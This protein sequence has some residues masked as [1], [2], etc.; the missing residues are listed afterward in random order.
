MAKSTK[1]GVLTT[2]KSYNFVDKDPII[3]AVRTAVSD[4]GLK[5]QQIKEKSGVSTA[6]LSG[7]L[8]GK[9]KRPQ[10]CTVAAVARACGK[11]GLRWG[12]NSSKP[13]FID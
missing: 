7:W 5:Y 11:K 2:Y 12:H 1:R 8:K 6:T 13:E 4:S 9:T 3:D 10:F